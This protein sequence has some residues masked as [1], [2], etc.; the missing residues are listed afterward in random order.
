M[1][2]ARV[3]L[4]LTWNADYLP[5][6]PGL[7]NWTELLSVPNTIL[8]VDSIVRTVLSTDTIPVLPS[9]L[10]AVELAR[11]MYTEPTYEGASRLSCISQ[12]WGEYPVRVVSVPVAR[13]LADL[14]DSSKVFHIAFFPDRAEVWRRADWEQ[15][16]SKKWNDAVASREPTDNI[17]ALR[18]IIRD[19]LIDFFLTRTKGTAAT[20]A[21]AERVADL[22]LGFGPANDGILE[23][24]KYPTDKFTRLNNY[25][26]Q[27]ASAINDHPTTT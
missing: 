8:K 22:L 18:R 2:S 15:S 17:V 23:L 19:E 11:F 1:P 6:P 24:L 20:R 14:P 25:R 4:S 10:S 26:A 13:V 21:D 7:W 3:T 9:E 5:D 16:R 27:V 12:E